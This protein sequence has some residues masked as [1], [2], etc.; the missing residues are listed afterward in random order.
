MRI[1]TAEA[2]HDV[3]MASALFSMQGSTELSIQE[4]LRPLG[5][6]ARWQGFAELACIEH[7][8][9]WFRMPLLQLTHHLRQ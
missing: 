5:Q 4:S 9:P 8:L 2:R 7:A 3:P 6:C 1:A